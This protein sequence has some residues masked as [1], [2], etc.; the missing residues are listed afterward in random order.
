VTH[1]VHVPWRLL[2]VLTLAGCATVGAAA[3]LPHA[4][5][6]SAPAPSSRLASLV[7]QPNPTR[8]LYQLTNQL[9]LHLS[10]P[11]A[12]VVRTT[13]PNYRVGH[14]ETFLVLSE[15][16]NKY[17]KMRATIRAKSRH[18]YMYVQNGVNV[19]SGALQQTVT[20]FEKSIYPTDRHYFGSEWR[21]GV[22]GDPHVICLYGDLRSS[23]AAGFYSAED[24]FPRQVN[25]WSNQHEMF[26]MNAADTTP[27]TAYFNLVLSHEFQHMI[28]WHMHPGDSAWI[29]EGMS[30]LA[31]QLNNHPPTDEAQS[32]LDL[33]TTQLDT[34]TVHGPAV[35]PH[36]GGA[37]L[38]LQYLDDHYG[39]AIIREMLADRK[40]TDIALVDDALHRLHVKTSAR[41]VFTRWV[42][43]NAIN[44]KSVA[45]GQYAYK[46]FS[47]R[48]ASSASTA[49]GSTYQAPIP[50]WAAQYIDVTGVE[51]AKPFTLSFSAPRSVP[52]VRFA[53][54]S[55]SGTAP[56][57]WSNR[58][59]M[60]QTELTRPVDLSHVKSAA[61][62]FKTAYDIEE[63]YD[64]VYMEAS[65]DGGKEWKTLPGTDTTNKNPTGANFGN[66]FTGLS[67]YLRSET[68]NLT[69]YAGKRILLRFQYV[70]DDEYNGQGMVIKDITIPQ[71]H[72]KDNLSGWTANGW[73]PMRSDALPSQW[74]LQ[75]IESTSKGT[76]VQKVP[77]NSVQHGS[78]S[79]NPARL[80]LKHLRA[81]VFS[82]A[83]KTTVQSTFT[84]STSTS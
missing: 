19:D 82:T 50:P 53:N 59:D 41:S 83:P 66:G 28:H 10:H 61:L 5:T 2:A 12:R 35:V 70:T 84:L 54:V 77:L 7:Q 51:N 62:H 45:G 42:I 6:P 73:I 15:D 75:L 39:S 24:E 3:R 49:L 43:A 29:N 57:W 64:Y 11:I 63:N 20:T 32:F 36:Y 76:L 27:G 72:F 65:T 17:F 21:P 18:M 67:S 52:L 33:P 81:V 46:S 58:G 48:I 55:V 69:P 79:I 56:G 74:T 38:F 9:K 60:M 8:N 26:Y 37:Y 71:I 47:Q 1:I 23:T 14:Q 78:I 22:D 30:T 68:V 13:S 25:P 31:E 4:Q 44:D 16:A 80:G 40:Y 34:W